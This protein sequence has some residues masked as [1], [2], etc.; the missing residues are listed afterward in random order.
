MFVYIYRE[1]TTITT[2]TKRLDANKLKKKKSIS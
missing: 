1:K 2:T